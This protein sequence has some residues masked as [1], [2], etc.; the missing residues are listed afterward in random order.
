MQKAE[1]LTLSFAR[2]IGLV[3]EIGVLGLW[4]DLVVSDG[5]TGRTQGFL[6]DLLRQMIEAFSHEHPERATRL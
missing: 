3:S 6:P 1:T 2:R 4:R 5:G